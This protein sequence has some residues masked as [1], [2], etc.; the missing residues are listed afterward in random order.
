LTVPAV[1]IAIFD[2]DDTLYDCLGQRVR[3]AHRNAARELVR[4]GVPASTEAVL[5]VRMQALER[6]PRLEPID[7]EVCRRFGVRF[8]Q[9]LHQLS[10]RA[11]FTTP[12]GRLRL[13]PG[14]RQLLRRI[15]GKGVR[16]FVVSYGNPATQRA[17]VRALGLDGEPA[18]DRILYADTGKV[19]TKEALFRRILRRY[20]GDAGSFLVVGDR[21]TSEIR[22]GK[23][24]GMRTVRIRRGEFSRLQAATP[25]EKAD[26]EVQDIRQLLALPLH[27]GQRKT[28]SGKAH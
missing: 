25:E 7:R 1:R 12:V 26:F 21:P 13:F 28:T 11:Y 22:A 2:L 17:K 8:T 27:F 5:R 24:L 15:H 19:T 20:G 10:R 23:R 14:A 3:V 18:V 9:R 6:D 4:A 16:V